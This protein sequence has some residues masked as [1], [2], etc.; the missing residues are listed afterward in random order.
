MLE[1]FISI[2]VEAPSWH[3]LKYIPIRVHADMARG[4]VA[5]IVTCRWVMWKKYFGLKTIEEEALFEEI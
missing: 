1:P 3:H 5:T 2:N 4:D